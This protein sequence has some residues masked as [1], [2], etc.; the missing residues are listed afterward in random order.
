VQW[1]GDDDRASAKEA[2][3]RQSIDKWQGET[4]FASIG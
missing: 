3:A 4:A 2:A 1:I